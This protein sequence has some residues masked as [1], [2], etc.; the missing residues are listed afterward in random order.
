MLVLA[1]DDEWVW[2]LAVEAQGVGRIDRVADR[3][4]GGIDVGLADDGFV[5]IEELYGGEEVAGI[6]GAVLGFGEME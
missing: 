2:E 4:L 5:V 3:V 6:T 1:C